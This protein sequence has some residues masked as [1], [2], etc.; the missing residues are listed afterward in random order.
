VFTTVVSH[1]KS[2]GWGD[3]TGADLDQGDGQGCYNATRVAA[4]EALVSW[5]DGDPTVSGDPDVFLV[6][7]F[8][9][10]AKED[11]IDVLVAAGYVDLGRAFDGDETYSYVFDGQWG[12]LDYAFASSSVVDRV[13]GTT[14]YHINADEV[15]VLDYNTDFKSAGQI[16]SLFA[17]DEFRTSDHDPI[18]V[19]FCDAVAPVASASATPNV[20]LPPNNKYVDVEVTLD[21]TDGSTVTTTLVSVEQN[22]PDWNPKKG[23]DVV[24]IDDTHFRLRATRIEDGAGKTYSIT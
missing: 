15:P 5:L 21:V 14:E 24:V 9:S 3:A 6:G 20:L 11:P 19:G 7:D 4:A 23:P 22:E 13:T 10:Y 18:I 12:Y 17:P 1:F 8:N 2:K 16:A